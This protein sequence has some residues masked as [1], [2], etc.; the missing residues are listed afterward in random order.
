M[1]NDF[2]NN[3]FIFI[4]R[5]GVNRRSCADLHR[6]KSFQSTTVIMPSIKQ[7]HW[8]LFVLFAAALCGNASAQQ[9]R[10]YLANDDHTDYMWTA[11]EAVYD[12]AFVHMLDYYLAQIDSTSNL[13]DDQQTRFNCDGSYWI[14]AYEKYRSPRQ[15][16]KLI[17][18]V[19]SGHISSPLNFL[20]NTYGAQPT[21]A[22]LRGM[23]SA[24]QLERDQKLRFPLAVAMEN[25]T[26]P[27]GLSSLWAGA[28][29][30]YSWRGVCGCATR[31]SNESLSHRKNQLYKYTGLDGRSVMMK[32][33]ARTIYNGRTLGG[34]AEARREK[35]PATIDADMGLMIKDLDKLCDNARSSYP[36]SVAGAFGYGWDDL[37]SYAAP[38]F[39]KAA[40]I[41]ST[42]L[43]KVRVSNEADFFE[44]VERNYPKL[45]SETVSFGN[46][47]DTYCAS[48]NE[49]TAKVRRATEK[50]RTAEA[51]ATVAA[52]K[53]KDFTGELS[54]L[55]KAA[56]E[57]YGAY[58][59]HDWTADA[60]VTQAQADHGLVTQKQRAAWQIKLQE[61]ITSYVDALY[62]ASSKAL[63][64]RIGKGSGSV[65]YVFNP[66]SWVRS[67]VADIECSDSNMRVTDLSNGKEIASQAISKNGKKYI[68]FI[69]GN[70]PSVG[71]KLYALKSGKPSSQTSGLKV[72]GEYISN[73]FFRLR[74]K[75]SGVITEWK[76]SLAGGRSL[77]KETYGKYVN[78]L[79]TKDL[80]AGTLTV[81]NLGPVSLTVKA[82]SSDPL[83]HTVRLTIFAASPRIEIE[84]SIQ[85]NFGDLKTWAFSF[86][87]Y[88]PTTHHEELGAVLT[89]KKNTRGGN[90][91]TSNT[92]YD[93]LTFNHF[94]D[95]SE[96]DYGVT[97]SNT[98]CSFFT[99]GRST[100]DSL[101]ET[102][103]QINALAG[104]QT[105]PY[106]GLSKNIK[107]TVMMGI[108]R[109]GGETNFRY[110]FALFSHQAAFDPLSQ[111]KASLEHQNPLL[112][113][114]ATG[115]EGMAKAN[116]F[117]LLKVDDPSVIVWSVKPAEEGL[118]NGII[119]RLWNF[120][121]SSISTKLSL[122]TP[123]T[124]AWQ[125]SHIE[126][127][128]KRLNPMNGALPVTL[129][130]QQI[131]T[132]RLLTSKTK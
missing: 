71:Y 26:L 58:W 84:D 61:Q 116:S 43:R 8:L 122:A 107:D 129:A 85:A 68:R 60:V 70:V 75:P 126:T 95:V 54:P 52:L 31:F 37:S 73:K 109:Q 17:D 98:D 46:E 1:R 97:L 63:A 123:L 112:A 30:K 44:D 22:V 89:A 77:I 115:S 102:S 120:K 93:W 66:L 99:L 16:K 4:P 108:Y 119:A 127:N 59:E 34:Y 121:A 40:K 132:Y 110:Q 41:Y 9:R 91:G 20:V 105:D 2:L 45:P 11:N 14:R 25:Q 33:Y 62:N 69:A 80:S 28:G 104:G 114:R 13:P 3:R 131:N 12:S 42:P 74:V 106:N 48:M 87:L 76:D 50:L 21:E 111:M 56:W 92:R 101:W 32:W 128:E 130:Q 23:Y 36:Y 96:K 15:Y 67:D 117:S 51:L 125:T 88:N 103:A 57:A 65:F 72:D 64:A 124:A 86:D 55:R 94:A 53:G 35:K 18:A 29:A 79:G 6:R 81:E 24:G 100:P 38:A 49:T 47:W 118:N 39:S 113:Q 10:F 82:V 83:P 7:F 90:Y 78:D 27:L 19:R 5:K